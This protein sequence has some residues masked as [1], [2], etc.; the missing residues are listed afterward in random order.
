MSRPSDEQ[1][2]NEIVKLLGSA[3]EKSTFRH[4]LPQN[5]E[6]LGSVLYILGKSEDIQLAAEAKAITASM[7]EFTQRARDP[8]SRLIVL[9]QQMKREF[10]FN[11]GYSIPRNYID[12]SDIDLGEINESVAQFA[13]AVSED[14]ELDTVERDILLSEI[15]LL[16]ASLGFARL[17]PEIITRFVSGVLRGAIVLAASTTIRT[18][19]SNLAERLFK[20][21]GWATTS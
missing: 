4:D 20:L 18:A 6:W 3:P 21:L 14:N 1:I 13:K 5:Q 9:L 7:N 2:L 15:A 19:A 10:E 12:T 16:E 8:Q 17:S 11:V